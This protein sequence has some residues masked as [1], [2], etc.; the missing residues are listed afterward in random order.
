MTA[1]RRQNSALSMLAQ[2]RAA[3]SQAA[4]VA[5]LILGS[6]G[7]GLTDFRLAFVGGA[8]AWLW[9][10]LEIGHATTR[11]TVLAVPGL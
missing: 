4:A 3:A 10:S 6:A 9:T 1:R 7:S 11:H 8:I 2:N 5:S